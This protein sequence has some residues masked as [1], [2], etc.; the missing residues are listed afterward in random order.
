MVADLVA[1]DAGGLLADRGRSG[2]CRPGGEHRQAEPGGGKPGAGKQRTSRDF[3]HEM[4]LPFRA[5]ANLAEA[6]TL[7]WR[8]GCPSRTCEHAS[9]RKIPRSDLHTLCPSL[10]F[11]GLSA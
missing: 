8:N 2:G 9:S 11:L 1:V 6:T 7:L 10:D 5:A 3:R 4:I